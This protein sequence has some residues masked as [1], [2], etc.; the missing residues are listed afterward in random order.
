MKRE[1]IIVFDVGTSS[2][3]T[4]AID[5]HNGRIIGLETAQYP[6]VFPRPEYMEIKPEM[7]WGALQSSLQTLLS[8]HDSLFVHCISFSWFSD[9]LVLCD[10]NYEPTT[11]IILYFDLRAKD[12]YEYF[13]KKN[14]EQ[15][16]KKLAIRPVSPNNEP[17]KVLWHKQNQPKTFAR[18]KYMFDNQQF[19]FSRLHVEP[20]NDDS[21]SLFKQVEDV[22]NRRWSEE[23]L[24]LY[25][26]PREMCKERIVGCTT[27]IGTVSSVGDVKLPN[28]NVP[29]IAGAHDELC[30]AMGVGVL[31]ENGPYIADMMGTSDTIIFLTDYSNRTDFPA[32]GTLPIRTE[33]GTYNSSG[34]GFPLLGGSLEWYVKQ[35]HAN[36]SR[37][38]L[39]ERLFR[40]AKFDGSNNVLMVPWFGKQKVGIRGI[41]AGTTPAHIFC[42][43][44]EGLTYECSYSM[45]HNDELMV[46]ARGEHI[47]LVRAAGGGSQSDEWLQLRASI[48][49]IP[50]QRTETPNSCSV[51]AAILAATSMGIYPSFNEASKSMVRLGKTFEPDPVQRSIYMEK[52]PKFKEFHNYI[53]GQ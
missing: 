21:M 24:D 19:V 42:A 30:G 44:V 49:G 20:V 2:V 34:R 8:K 10:E 14:P 53:M 31:P 22:P 46:A 28:P 17:M 5:I 40:E 25:E 37:T 35:Y 12:T 43:L 41:T 50:V 39:F 13:L 52:E 9:N 16:C 38:G 1:V 48:F 32:T 23:L 29:V 11:N 45:Q 47:S 18:S 6:A 15:I 26:I 27:V 4:S 36:E 3:K 51:G 33:H 7:L